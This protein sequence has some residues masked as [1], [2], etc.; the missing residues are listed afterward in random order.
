MKRL[1]DLEMAKKTDVN[2]KTTSENKTTLGVPEGK[3]TESAS[4]VTRFPS[5][6]DKA[7]LMERRKAPRIA[8]TPPAPDAPP[9]FDDYMSI[10]GEAELNEIRHIASMLKGK[11]DRKSVVRER[12]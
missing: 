7:G 8:T 12:V 10:V 4:K 3:V 2:E 5:S 11:T 6:L 1:G 9:K